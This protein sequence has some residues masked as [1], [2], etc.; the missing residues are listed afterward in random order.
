LTRIRP[1]AVGFRSITDAGRAK[2]RLAQSDEALLRLCRLC[3]LDQASFVRILSVDEADAVFR[4]N[5]LLPKRNGAAGSDPGTFDP[6]Y[7]YYTLGKLQILSY[8]AIGS[9]GGAFT[10]ATFHDEMLRHGAPP[11]RLLRE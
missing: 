7:L 10:F 9:T 3:L 6:E 11:L 2:Y 4:D 1:N 5:C 8:A